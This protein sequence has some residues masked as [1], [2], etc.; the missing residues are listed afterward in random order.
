MSLLLG[1]ASES[2]LRS[3]CSQQTQT[4]NFTQD[5]KLSQAKYLLSEWAWL[6]WADKVFLT[7]MKDAIGRILTN[8]S[9]IKNPIFIICIGSII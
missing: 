3:Q 1:T 2:L 6:F 5:G 9:N 4:S 7:P 8:D